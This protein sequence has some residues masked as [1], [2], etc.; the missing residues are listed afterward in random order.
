MA[1]AAGP[2]GQFLL[3]IRAL[4][5][6]RIFSCFKGVL[7]KGAIDVGVRQA[8]QPLFDLSKLQTER[9]KRFFLVLRVFISVRSELAID[10][11][12]LIV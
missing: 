1:V 9:G 11:S 6:E 10:V 4:H 12:A 8:V 7:V 2:V 3:D 5:Q